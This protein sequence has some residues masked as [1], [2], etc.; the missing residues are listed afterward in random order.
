MR[1]MY[2]ANNEYLELK[3]AFCL[4]FPRIA[5]IL[6]G[7][8]SFDY[9]ILAILL[10]AVER[11]VVLDRIGLEILTSD[12]QIPFLT[13]HDAI[14][15]TRS[16]MDFVKCTMESEMQKILGFVPLLRP[17]FLGPEKVQLSNGRP[18]ND[19]FTETLK[20]DGCLFRPSDIDKNTDNPILKSLI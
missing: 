3:G 19:Y 12:P 11:H 1:M 8:K 20:L 15:T 17:K 4:L 14:L 10:Q 7:I 6:H 18:F 13:V 5:K 16:R 9:K 2:S